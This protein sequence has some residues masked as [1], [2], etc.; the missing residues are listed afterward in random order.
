MTNDIAIRYCNEYLSRNIADIDKEFL[1]KAK[2]ALQQEPCEDCWSKQAVMD[3]FKKWQPYM[4]TKLGEFEKE[5]TALP[6][7]IPQQKVG[8][9]I[10]VDKAKEHAR[11]SQCGYG[12]VDL[13]D[14][15]A[16]NYCEKCGT[17]MAEPLEE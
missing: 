1:K 4:A 8:H 11:C 17:R 16:H 7:V 5:L 13:V 3:C 10:F 12:D 14:G 6:P 15:R 2:E 9:W